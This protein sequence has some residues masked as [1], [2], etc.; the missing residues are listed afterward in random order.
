MCIKIYYISA[1]TAQMLARNVNYEI[2]AM[3]KQISKCQ[4]LQKVFVFKGKL[5]SSN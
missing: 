1:E 5:P 4:Q 2:P 3:K